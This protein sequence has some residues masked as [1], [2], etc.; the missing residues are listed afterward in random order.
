MHILCTYLKGGHEGLV[1]GEVSGQD[2]LFHQR[3]DLLSLLIWQVVQQTHLSQNGL[4]GPAMM[5]LQD[6]RLLQ[7]QK[8]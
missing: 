5:L 4:G 7:Q 3:D 8:I 6:A 2:K 1:S